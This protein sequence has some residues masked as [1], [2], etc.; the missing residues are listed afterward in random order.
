MPL[1]LAPR[2]AARSPAKPSPA[3]SYRKHRLDAPARAVTHEAAREIEV[4]PVSGS[5]GMRQRKRR[6]TERLPRARLEVEHLAV[7]G[8]RPTAPCTNPSE[9][10]ELL[11]DDEP[12]CLVARSARIGAGRFPF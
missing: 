3:G 10:V 11:L 4:G 7:R 6:R 9:N 8:D 5:P 12:L 2:V 1:L